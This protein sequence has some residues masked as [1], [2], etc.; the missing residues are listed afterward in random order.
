MTLWTAVLLAC[1]LAYAT[2]LAGHLVPPT[3]LTGRVT[4]RALGLLPVALLAALVGVQ[5]MSAP[6]PTLVLDAR[7]AGVAAALVALVLRAPFLVVLVVAA[8][9]AAGLRA[10][11]WAA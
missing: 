7:V 4:T 5:T 1:A 2:K 11:G 6:G 3:W 8:A 10:A 9:V